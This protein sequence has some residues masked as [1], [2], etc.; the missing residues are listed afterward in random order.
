M[1]C[2][3][4]SCQSPNTSVTR[5]F[6]SHSPQMTKALM[7]LNVNRRHMRC[8]EC[9]E[10]FTTVEMLESEFDEMRRPPGRLEVE[11]GRVRA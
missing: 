11:R 10:V 1:N 4:Q 9:G 7:G 8:D 6:K 2:P 5:T 3:R